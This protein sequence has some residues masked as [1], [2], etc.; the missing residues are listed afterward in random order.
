M[1]QS[2]KAEAAAQTAERL[3][4]PHTVNGWGVDADPENDPTWP[5]RDRSR[6][7]SPDKSWTRPPQQP[8]TVEVLQSNEH[9]FRP[10][11]FGTSTPP[12]GLSGVIR[13]RAFVFSESQWAHWLL[14]MLAD[15]IN[16]VE[17]L[18]HDLSRGKVPNVFAEM[19]GPAELKHNG[20]QRIVAA[21]TT[22]AVAAAVIGVG[23]YLLRS[24]ND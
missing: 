10:A 11:V 12:S 16:V 7:R 13:R 1:T 8:E 15:R 19:G 17:G 18:L 24:R 3:I 20:P 2:D 6:D 4:D 5:M 21:V 22:V 23:V 14:L 9:L